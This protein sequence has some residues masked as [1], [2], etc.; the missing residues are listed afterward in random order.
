MSNVPCT[1]QAWDFGHRTITHQAKDQHTARY[2]DDLLPTLNAPSPINSELLARYLAGEADAAQQRSVEDWAAASVENARELERMRVLWNLGGAST[3]VPEM[4]VDAA[5][6]KLEARIA[7]AEG[8]ERARTIGGTGTSWM[9]WVAAAAVVAGLV[10]AARWS[11]R[12]DGVEHFAHTEAVEV[13]LADES[14]SVL[15]PGTR[16]EERMGKRRAIRL[17]GQAYFE[18]QRDEQRPFTVEAGDVEVTVLG[19]AFEVS[20]YDTSDIV[21]VRV[22]SG[23]VRV[24]AGGETIELAAGEHAVFHKERH[25]LERRAA[26]P[27]EVWGIRILQFEGASLDQ[28]ATQLERIYKVR[29]TLRNDR[30]AACRLT[31]EFDD[32]TISTIIGVIAE[33]FS[34]DVQMLEGT[35][36]LD[37]DG[38]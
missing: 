5:W 14:R 17:Q 25:F 12:A 34:L 9:R 28:V 38:C 29:V 27:A 21:Q 22:R 16:I 23:R 19:T 24:E 7:D 30:I 2:N 32:E 20:A 33:T 8:R 37:G 26:P 35:F 31:A 13:L 36:I 4:D 3:A 15:S 6:N 11:M 18:V 10:F 1:G